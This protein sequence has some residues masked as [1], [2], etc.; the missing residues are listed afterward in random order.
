MFSLKNVP[1]LYI[2]RVTAYTSI[3]HFFY[4]FQHGYAWCGKYGQKNEDEYYAMYWTSN[5]IWMGNILFM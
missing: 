1:T 3:T 2:S 5:V 4:K